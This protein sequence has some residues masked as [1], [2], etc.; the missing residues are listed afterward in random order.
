[1]DEKN[2]PDKSINKIDKEKLKPFKSRR[3]NVNEN[4]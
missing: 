3:E 2:T 4:S 1:M